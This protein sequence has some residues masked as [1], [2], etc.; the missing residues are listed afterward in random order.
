MDS[1]YLYNRNLILNFHTNMKN[2]DNLIYGIL[3]A[4]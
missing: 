2:Q 1:A 4:N 3:F